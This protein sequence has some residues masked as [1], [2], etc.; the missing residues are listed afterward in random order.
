MAV[1]NWQTVE[2]AAQLNRPFDYAL[3]FREGAC[4]FDAPQQAEEA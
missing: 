3:R 4:R 1:V 2:G